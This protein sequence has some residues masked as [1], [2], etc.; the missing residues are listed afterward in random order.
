MR[1]TAT[2]LDGVLLI[3]STPFHDHRGS[4]TKL[5]QRD[6]FAR[7]GIN[8]S[9][10][11]EFVSVSKRN[12]V[13][14]MHFQNPPA[15]HA[16][17]VYCVGGAVLDVVV[18]LRQSSPTFGQHYSRELTDS[19]GEMLLIPA[20]FAHGFLALVDEATMIYLTTAVHSPEHDAGILWSSFGFRWPVDA[21]LLSP[22]DAQFPALAVFATPF[23]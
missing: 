11:E 3:N 20:G 9:V 23:R 1:A 13:R 10:A 14:G 12:V 4:F 8:F 7:L 5:Y 6:L 2:P 17:L 19:S 21:P 15:A 22:R 18:D 16:K